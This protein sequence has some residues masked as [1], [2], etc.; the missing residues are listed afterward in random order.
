MI[1]SR[2]LNILFDGIS[3]NCVLDFSRRLDKITVDKN[4]HLNFALALYSFALS[5]NVEQV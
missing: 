2:K 5:W 3:A 4:V 1:S